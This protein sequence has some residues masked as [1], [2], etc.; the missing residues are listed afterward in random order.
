MS[1]V[2]KKVNRPDIIEC[3][4]FV[5]ATGWKQMTPDDYKQSITFRRKD[6]SIPIVSQVRSDPMG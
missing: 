2:L 3:P 5:N 1:E 6:F 4:S